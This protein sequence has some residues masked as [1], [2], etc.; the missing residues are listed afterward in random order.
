MPLSTLQISSVRNIKSCN[1][2]LHPE[3]NLFVGANGSGKSSLLEAVYLMFT[4]RSFRSRRAL[5][6]ITFGEL[7]C[8][9]Y[10]TFFSNKDT[11]KS[12]GLKK[13]LNGKV[14]VKIDQL[15]YSS[16]LILAKLNPVRIHSPEE[17]LLTD[18]SA[19]QGRRFLDWALFHVEH[20]YGVLWKRCQK[21]IKHRNALV[22]SGVRNYSTLE[23]W[24]LQLCSLFEQV[25]N[26]RQDHID[27]LQASLSEGPFRNLIEELNLTLCLDWGWN[28][29]LS[30]I[31][32]MKSSFNKDISRGY[33]TL[34]AHRATMKIKSGDCNSKDILS[35]G[36]KK[37]VTLH[38]KMLQ[39]SL[40][41]AHI[42]EPP[43]LLLDD[44]GAELDH[45]NLQILFNW[46]FQIPY[47]SQI[48]I[49]SISDQV[50]CLMKGRSFKMF[51]V[52]HGDASQKNIVV[53]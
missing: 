5:N 2:D 17:P 34:G 38:L 18:A 24:D 20:D 23:P 8:V 16:A 49:T 21:L 14:S 27:K 37:A 40:V 30:L 19:E 47:V 3:I 9:I 51:H 36:Q 53:Q 10:A 41:G 45:D 22:R 48:F 28:K 29:K 26:L 31:E 39:S 50:A 43:I 1:L 4:G 6:Y 7:S 13:M 46:I 12:I 42:G 35:R 52:E 25:N 15:Q 33:T 11:N 32:Q 44:I